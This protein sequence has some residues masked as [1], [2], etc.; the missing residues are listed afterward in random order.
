[1]RGVEVREYGAGAHYFDY[2]VPCGHDSILTFK[3]IVAFD[4]MILLRHYA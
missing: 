1:V 3:P 2:G 4:F